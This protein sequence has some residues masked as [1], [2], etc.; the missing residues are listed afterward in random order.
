VKEF[1]DNE[2]KI[3]AFENSVI[4]QIGYDPR[5]LNPEEEAGKIMAKNKN[6]LFN[7]IFGNIR[8]EEMT[9]GMR[10]HWSNEQNK[11]YNRILNELKTKKTNGEKTLKMLVSRFE[12]EHL[13]QPVHVKEGDRVVAF[14]KATG[15]YEDVI[16]EPKK[17]KANVLQAHVITEIEKAVD[18]RFFDD[19]D[20]SK[21]AM[22]GKVYESLPKEK[23]SEHDAITELAKKI[24]QRSIDNGKSMTP[25]EAVKLAM[26][27]IEKDKKVSLGT[28]LTKETAVAILKEA[29]GDKN[30]A[31]QI[32]KERGY[33]L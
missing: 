12:K 18:K 24:M 20:E 13:Q 3:T 21:I 11:Y 4:K 2:S 22:G 32:A 9:P 28:K 7:R 33:S 14:N 17:G 19:A 15:K 29:K 23:R 27:N 25:D 1:A 10:Q 31:R 5:V 16:S 26:E 30:K 8:Q 6:H